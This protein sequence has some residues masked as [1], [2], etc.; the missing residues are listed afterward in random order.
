MMACLEWQHAVISQPRGSAPNSYVAMRQLHAD[1]CVCPVEAA[2]QECGG[3]PQRHGDDRLVEILLVLVL[4]QRQ[5]CT[6][7]VPI[8]QTGVGYEFFETCL[9]RRIPGQRE[10]RLRHWRPRQAALRVH[11][12]VTIAGSVRHPTESAAIC[13]CNGHAKT[14]RCDHVAEWGLGNHIAEAWQDPR[15]LADGEVA[16]NCFTWTK[17]LFTQFDIRRI[18]EQAHCHGPCHYVAS[19]KMMPTV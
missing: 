19:W 4:M 7:V 8:D 13:H 15:F 10:E 17:G 5:S 3:E 12:V 9:R 16:Q 14:A 11:R 1:C 6:A 2:E 18:F